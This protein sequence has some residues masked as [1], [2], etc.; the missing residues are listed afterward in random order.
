MSS[1]SSP[2]CDFLLFMA[3]ASLINNSSISIPKQK[4]WPSLFSFSPVKYL[5][6]KFSLKSQFSVCSSQYSWV[7]I[8]I[9]IWFH[10]WLTVGSPWQLYCWCS[11]ELQDIN[12]KHFQWSCWIMFFF[13]VKFKFDFFT[14]LLSE[15]F[16]ISLYF[17][18]NIR[19]AAYSP[20]WLFVWGGTRV[21]SKT[22]LV[23]CSLI[24][25]SI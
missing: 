6:Q 11:V 19:D 9:I 2:L 23:I 10:A 15:Y 21:Q 8:I 20:L 25:L 1:S 16:L 13:L 12:N 4:H 7:I 18:A 22:S 5:R 17:S 14:S 24:K 3:Y